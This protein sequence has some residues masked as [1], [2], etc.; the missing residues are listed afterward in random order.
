MDTAIALV[1]I[2][3]GMFLLVIEL[4]RPGLF[5]PS[6]IGIGL[7]VLGGTGLG[8]TWILIP[9]VLAVLALMTLSAALTIRRVRRSSV[10]T[11][12]AALVGTVAVARTSLSPEGMVFLQGERWQARIEHGAASVGERVVIV[13]ADGFQLRVRKEVQDA[14]LRIGIHRPARPT[15]GETPIEPAKGT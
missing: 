7:L 12:T 8:G 5:I 3:V 14:E 10:A 4:H 1:L 13:G 9:V 15:P 6:L 11:G 2:G